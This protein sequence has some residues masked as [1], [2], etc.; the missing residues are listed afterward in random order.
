M[1]QLLADHIALETG[2]TTP[3]SWENLERAYHTVVGDF[4]VGSRIRTRVKEE[5]ASRRAVT[6]METVW[7][8][9]D[10]VKKTF[11]VAMRK[12][13]RTSMGPPDAAAPLK[14]PGTEVRPTVPLVIQQLAEGTHVWFSTAR[15]K[16]AHRKLYEP[17]VPFFSLACNGCG[18]LTARRS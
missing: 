14:F 10:S 17:G 13:R 7:G 12:K 15:M 2:E 18:P 4:T 3:V 5:V 8:T 6:S 9:S 1:V 16:Q 11:H